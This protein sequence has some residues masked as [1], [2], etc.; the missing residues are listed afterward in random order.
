MSESVMYKPD[1]VFETSWEVC[2]KVGGIYTVVSTKV[3][4]LVKE[5]K[6]KYILFGPDVWKET[7][8]NPEFTEDKYLFR[9]WREKAEREGLHFKVGRWNIE[10][11]PIVILV[12][13]T[14]YFQKK[15]EIFAEFWE[16]Y[17]LDS[18]NGQWDYIEPAIF[19]Y[20]TARII[21]SF[22]SFHCSINDRLIAHFHEWMTGTGIL[23]LH[24][25]TPQ[26]ATVFTTH[27]TAV[28]RSIAGNNL[29]LYGNMA[30]FK[31][32][33]IA[34]EFNLVSKYSLEKLSA[35]VADCFTTVSDLTSDEC[36][37]F[38]EK[39]VDF[40]TPNGFDDSF[41][42]KAD[43]F[44]EKRQIARNRLLKVAEAVTACP[45]DPNSMLIVN[46]GR[47]EYRN[48]GINLFIDALAILNK[49]KDLSRDIVAV[50]AVPANHAGPRY[51]VLDRLDGKNAPLNGFDRHLT[52]FLHDQ[53]FDPILK[54]LK[55][56]QLNNTEN[57]RVK[58]LFI[59]VY[60]NG[61]DGIVNLSYYDT[62]IGFDVS[63]FPSY[64][65][66]WGYTPLESLAFHIPTI[67]TTLAGFGL[68]VRAE[69]GDIRDGVAVI[70]R[71][72]TNDV[73]VAE[74]IAAALYK[75]NIKNAEERKYSY[76][77]AFQISR[78]ALWDNLV[79][80]YYKAFSLALSKVETRQPS[81]AGKAVLE[82]SPADKYLRREKPEWRKLL[83]KPSI[84]P[85]LKNLQ[86]L[87][88]NLKW[89]W[90]SEIIDL[91]ESINP[92]LFAKCNR[93]PYQMLETLSYEELVALQNNKPLLDR[94][95]TIYLKFEE[96]MKA[97]EHKVKRQIAYFSMEF[98]IHDSVKIFS[99]GLGLLA[100]D[101]LKEASDRNENMIGI[102][103]LYRY[104]YFR[105][106][107]TASGE[108]IADYQPQKFSHIAIKP[109]RN[110]DG[111]WVM[112]SVALPGRSLMAKVWQAD[113]GRIPLYL[114]D[115]DIDENSEQDR[116]ITH[117]LYGGDWENR[118]KQELLL[119]V[120]GIR[121]LDV[122][123]I[124][125]NVYHC[126]EGHA[127]FI[128]IERLRKLVQDERLNFYQ[129]I[130]VVKSSSLFTTHTPV[131]AG[132][133]MFSESILRTYIPHY[134]DRLKISWDT[135]MDLGREHPGNHEEKFSM[136]VL[137]ANLSQ[138]INGVSRIHGRVSREMFVEMYEGFFAREL[139]I[140]YVTN[141]AHLPTWAASEWMDL[142]KNTF[143]TDFVHSQSNTDMWSKI[144][145]VSDETIWKIRTL[146]RKRLIDYLRHRL[147]KDLTHRHENPKTIFKMMEALNENAL[148]I[149]F[150]R[151]FATYKRAHLLFQNLER[152]SEL[153]NRKGMPVHF[154]FAGK[155]HPADKAGQDL[156]SMI[157]EISKRPAFIGKIT[158][159]E[160]YD[161][162]LAQ[163]LVRGVDIWLNT[164]TR[165]LEAS[166]TSGI[167]AS[168]NGVLN[169]SVLDGWW[170][171]GYV[172]GGGW[173]LKEERTY[174]NQKFQDDL[175]AENIYTL[176]EDEI[177]PLFYLR[178]QGQIPSKW[179]KCI[180][181]N[182]AEIVPRFT[183]SRM[184]IDYQQK[185]YEK[186]SERAAVVAGNHYEYANS[187]A[188]WKRKILRGWES[189]EIIAISVPDSTSRP[190]KLG[191]T[192]VAELEI[193]LHEIAGEDI[194]VEIIFANKE[195][196][197]ITDFV[198]IEELKMV[199]NGQG[200]K[201]KYRIEKPA[202]KS[203]VYDFVFRIFPRHP[204][205]PHRLDFP[206]VKWA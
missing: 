145:T 80:W 18:L 156:I 178:D 78:I 172:P 179:V 162:E 49:H 110:E 94:I 56:L 109:V 29:P 23:H 38:L 173:A 129:A 163:K 112:V 146:Q 2:N 17:H 134:A 75:C 50:I 5:F 57:D 79:D 190:L 196:D 95:E 149:G 36:T 101:Y 59:P 4:N 81:F 202:S 83:I 69:F 180:K 131:P 136:S 161:I 20:A 116:S 71:N 175:D 97:T 30:T 153:V 159:V 25:K 154:I 117:Q 85:A 130:E 14:Q 201:V 114:L 197:E 86:R 147:E 118:F 91:F 77:K 35:Q 176:L 192:F 187:L 74:N 166:G 93:N 128:G 44:L 87:S 141:G 151:R 58:V 200:G 47:Y 115:A 108:Q 160:N 66:P 135:F 39:S 61:S 182:F 26:I 84:P 102:G 198:S 126:N 72:D 170:A 22:Y 89:S 193:D 40:V 113:V 63:V 60:L 34:R 120:G 132:H 68:W 123:N 21:E 16:K 46:S 70:D 204:L 62:L 3:P 76:D 48:K 206:L 194:G 148:T 33:I 111:S 64:Y 7:H 124:H 27:A 119:G 164:P 54:Q 185:F 45:I 105:Q 169:F 144:H 157:V 10:G 42:P 99:G 12:E 104:G 1:Y 165:P 11:N 73:E 143:G 28:G 32:E 189:I 142:F 13:F 67:T 103:L 53:E 6:D 55:E 92:E 199:E 31:P 133:D 121:L 195:N 155:A 51:D 43:V 8:F 174:Q 168:M 183:M 125:P 186:L 9:A 127:A 52:H 150:A 82:Q 19:G 203:G 177:V 107:I 37:Y 24:D 152:L 138:E 181:K 122:L 171:E 140:D 137:A 88:K 100:G 167:K 65:E 41:V 191:E 90:D 158:F 106:I 98:G 184:L 15:D 205:L 188:N 96:Y 139:H